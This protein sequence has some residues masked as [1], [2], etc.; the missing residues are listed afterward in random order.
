MESENK[1]ISEVNLNNL[2]NYNHVNDEK[3]INT[4]IGKNADKLKK[5]FSLNTLIFGFFYILYRKMWL[6]GFVWIFISFVISFVV[7]LL[8]LS[9]VVT[10]VLELIVNLIMA[11]IF[12]KAYLKKVIEKVE[13]IKVRN[14]GKSN[15]ELIRLCAKK[16]GTTIIGVAVSIVI[17]YVVPFLISV[18]LG[19]MTLNNVREAAARD[20]AYSIISSVEFAYTE[21]FLETDK[22]VLSLEDVKAEY[23]GKFSTWNDDNTIKSKSYK[24]VCNVIVN[25]NNKMIV[26]CDVN[27]KKINSEPLS[28]NVNNNQDGE[29]IEEQN[30]ISYNIIS[31]TVSGG[32]SLKKLYV[33]KNLVDLKSTPTTIEVTQ[34]SDILIVK[35][36]HASSTLYAV[37]KAA[38]V[39]G[40][41]VPEDNNYYENI[42]K[43]V[44]K[45]NYR[46]KYRFEGNDLYITTDK[47]VQDPNYALC[48]RITNDDEIVVYEEKFTYLGNNKFSDSEVINTVTRKQ[49]MKEHNINCNNVSYEIVD[50]IDPD[51]LITF[52]QLYINKK[53]VDLKNNYTDMKVTKF[54]DIF[55]VEAGNASSKLYV[56]DKDANV[57]G[58]FVQKNQNF[59]RGINK[60]DTKG[61][62]RDT[63]RIDGNDLYI[64]TD[65]LSKDPTYYICNIYT[66]D[67][68]K[69]AY[70]EKF[71]YLGNNKFSNAEVVKTIKRK[72]YMQEHNISCSNKNEENVDSSSSEQNGIISI[73]PIKTEK[74]IK[75]YKRINGYSHVDD[76]K[77]ET[78]ISKYTC[79]NEEC[80][81]CNSYTVCSNLSVLGNNL[82]ALFDYDEGETSRTW[83]DV[84]TSHLNPVNVILWDVSKGKEIARY[85]DII[86]AYKLVDTNGDAKYIILENKNNKINMYDL[87]GNHIRNT[88]D[89]QYVLKSYEGRWI[90]SFS[91]L[92][93]NDMIV[94]IKNNK[95]GI[96]NITKDKTLVKHNYD[97]IVLYD[98]YTVRTDDSI[99]DNIR[100]LYAG[101]YFKARIGNK[102]SLYDIKMGKKVI[103][104]DYD[105]IYLL[106]ENTIAVYNDGYLYFVDYKGNKASDVKIKISNLFGTMPKNPEGIR[107]EVGNSIVNISITEGTDYDNWM[108]YSYEYNLK[109]KNLT[110]LS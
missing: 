3:L 73:L 68:Y 43:I 50:Y 97:E 29:T 35:A 39:I 102:W 61:D 65:F 19:M 9:A 77:N 36:S 63:Y 87:N 67:E 10:L 12:K 5:G 101:K 23:D 57:I 78:E 110:K 90:D 75:F 42:Q 6:L 56:V 92:V 31:E 20:S 108:N 22:D 11:F 2:S 54:S 100:E 109:T 80:N 83:I 81:Y 13:Q 49:Y 8:S 28:M 69:V 105:R 17:L 85:N 106:N 24:V 47:L 93:K 4:Y 16:G 55:V 107:F 18:F 99:S 32:L 89:E 27:D 91:Y 79:T 76:Y 88:S 40:V 104:E 45:A 48:N 15:E 59:F 44:S 60:I 14:I 82:I 95:H 98:N 51:T 84:T 58:A 21:A 86:S 52:K 38:N 7:E 94:T 33:N 62:Y 96:K 41:F 34:L 25:P 26:E 103:N 71:T 30:I 70:E 46:D 74:T 1:I 72:Q 64:T 53:I 37:D 66:G